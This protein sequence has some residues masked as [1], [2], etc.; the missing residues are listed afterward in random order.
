MAKAGRFAIREGSKK[1]PGSKRYGEVRHKEATAMGA[2][3][4]KFN[5]SA[6]DYEKKTKLENILSIADEAILRHLLRGYSVFLSAGIAVYYS[7]I[8]PDIISTD[9]LEFINSGETTEEMFKLFRPFC[10][11]YR[12]CDDNDKGNDEKCI[13]FDKKITMKYNQGEWDR[14]T[15]YRCHRHVLGMTFPIKVEGVL[16]GVL[17]GGQVVRMPERR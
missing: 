10:A 11:K 15:L 13:N 5:A 1:R 9:A 16:L 6:E 8:G 4:S 7:G 12:S 17:F 3:L 14:H 2:G